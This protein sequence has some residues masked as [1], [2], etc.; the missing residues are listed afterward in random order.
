[1]PIACIKCPNPQVHLVVDRDL[2]CVTG[3]KCESCGHQWKRS[4]GE[5]LAAADPAAFSEP[6]TRSA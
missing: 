2:D 5:V 1:M 3:F 6:K 4:L